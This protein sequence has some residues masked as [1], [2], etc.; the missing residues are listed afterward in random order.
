MAKEKYGVKWEVFL[1]DNFFFMWG[2]R[3][4]TD[5]NFNSPRLFHYVL[6]E[7]ADKLKELLD[8]SHC[9][10]KIKEI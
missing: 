3:P 1:D 7:D 2:V 6:K 5:K 4:I 8:K 10:V 9:A